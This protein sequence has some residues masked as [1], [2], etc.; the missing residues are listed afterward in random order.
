MSE[1]IAQATAPIGADA[2]LTI[3]SGNPIV[4]QLGPGGQGAVGWRHYLSPAVTAPGTW[5]AHRWNPTS[6]GLVAQLGT[7][8]DF[9]ARIENRV[10]WVRTLSLEPG[11]HLFRARFRMGPVS[12]IPNG[13]AAR[14]RVF[15]QLF[16]TFDIGFLP[17]PASADLPAGGTVDLGVG[18]SIPGRF[19]LYLW[20]SCELT[21][22][23]GA[24]PYC[25]TIVHDLRV[26]ESFWPLPQHAAGA[27][28][29]EP[30]GVEIEDAREED[31]RPGS[32]EDEWVTFEA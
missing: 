20:A 31:L 22:T 13:Q 18:I 29:I 21:R 11:S 4:R 9:G 23:A 30:S 26:E 8:G 24:K 19:V 10:G 32:A 15:A 17:A 28:R 6:G 2:A 1:A 7:A 25:E 5:R 16:P 14:A 3:S 27:E 12:E